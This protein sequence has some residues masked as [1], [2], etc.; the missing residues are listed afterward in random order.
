[1]SL[2]VDST[3]KVIFTKKYG[4]VYNS[5]VRNGSTDV[6]A[7]P[8]AAAFSSGPIKN[9]PVVTAYFTDRFVGGFKMNNS[10]GGTY[11]STN[12]RLAY[13]PAGNSIFTTDTIAAIAEIQ[14]PAIEALT[15]DNSTFPLA[16][17]K[18]QDWTSFIAD[19]SKIPNRIYDYNEMG[20]MAL[21]KV[22]GGLYVQSYIWYSGGS[23]SSSF[24]KIEDHTNLAASTVLGAWETTSPKDYD[25]TWMQELPAAWKEEFNAS[26]VFGNGAG[27]SNKER[28]SSG[29]SAYM[30]DLASFDT[31][32][33]NAVL[34]TQEVVV[35]E[36]DG[37]FSLGTGASLYV[38][39]APGSDRAND[40]A[41]AN[42]HVHRNYDQYNNFNDWDANE[43][44]PKW[45]INNNDVGLGVG[46]PYNAALVVKGNNDIWTELSSAAGTFIISGTKTLC[47]IGEMGGG[48]SGAGY[49]LG[50]YDDQGNYVG[51]GGGGSTVDPSDRVAYYWLYDMEELMAATDIGSVPP[52]AYGTLPLFDDVPG[53]PRSATYDPEDGVLLISVSGGVFSTEDSADTSVLRFQLPADA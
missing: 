28:A 48:E 13:N 1:M 47:A 51:S 40:P 37:T 42:K 26:H 21:D 6:Y 52:Y 33:A 10:L 3:K 9:N 27:M 35:Y 39:N 8:L 4:A 34:S 38:G 44:V 5:K 53:T 43:G 50:V 19:D 46:K 14:M 29:P 18:L 45:D 32:D 23:T 20:G 17:V 11:R 7:L 16:M 2:N 49:K 24:F 25:T 15:K 41:I 12:A 36:K 30:A 31:S 22:N